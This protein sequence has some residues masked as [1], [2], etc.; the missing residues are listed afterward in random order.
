MAKENQ[1]I[2]KSKSLIEF[3][4]TDIWRISETEL[5]KSKRRLYTLLK[6]LTV[7][8]RRFDED[9]LQTRASALTYSTLLAIVPILALLFAI[10]NG[11]GFK[12]LIETQLMDYFP[13]QKVVLEKGLEFASSYLESAKGGVFVGIGIIMLIWA[14][15]VLISHI[16]NAFN[17]IWLVKKPRSYYRKFTDYLSLFLILPVLMIASS[18]VSIFITTALESLKE[19]QVIS[20]VIGIFIRFIPFIITWLIF[21]SIYIFI[22]NTKV[23]FKHALIPA[24]L[25]CIAFQVFQYLYIGGQIWVTRYNAIYGSFAALPLLLLWLQ[26]SWLITLFGAEL[27]YASQN[28]HNFYFEKDTKHISRRYKDFV[29]LLIASI[30]IKQFENGGKPLRAKDISQAHHIPIRLTQDVLYLLSEIEIINESLDEDIDEQIYQPA[31][32]INKITVGLLLSRLDL[33]GSE[34]FRIDSQSKF[35]SQ[36]KSLLKSRE[37]MLVSANETLIKDLVIEEKR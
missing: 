33:H 15:I 1:I 28:I 26:V 16:E 12:T 30:V 4:T 13:G 6:A 19:F 37:E 8:I 34:V 35:Y 9:D 24:L 29:T 31:L 25:I 20:P 2:Q 11:L 18:G 7:S 5:S 17:D 3:V 36:W 21:L 32:D 23:S 27:C 14:V 10:A 22:P